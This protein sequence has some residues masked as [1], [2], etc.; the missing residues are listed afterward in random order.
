MTSKMNPSQVWVPGQ[1]LQAPEPK[2]G[3]VSVWAFTTIL[4]FEECPYRVYLQK[5]KKIKVDQS[6]NK[7]LVRGNHVH[8]LAENYVNGQITDMPMELKKFEVGFNQLREDYINGKVELEEN[9]GV[10]INWEPV[11]WKDPDLWGRIKL[12]AF[13]RESKT[14]AKCIDHKT[15]RKFGNEL[16]HSLQGMYYTVTAFE[17]YKELQF[18]ETAFWYLDKG[19]TLTKIYT[20]PEVDIIKERIHKR[21]LALTTAS[22]FPARPSAKNCKWCD[23]KDKG[24]DY[25]EGL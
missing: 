3:D 9:W 15:G 22:H 16:K 8:E 7:A 4:N 10:D 13:V 1:P 19:E 24:C 12:D 18:M 14:S 5:V 21:A 17:R 11:S 6:G 23:Y 20:R 2:S 25:A